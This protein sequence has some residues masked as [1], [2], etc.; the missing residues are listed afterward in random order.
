MNIRRAGLACVI[1]WAVS[2]GA[3]AVALDAVGERTREALALQREGRA[4]APTRPMPEP[5]AKRSYERYLE[6]FSHPIPE[7]FDRNDGFDVRDGR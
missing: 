6:S 5:A 2:F 4:A 1:G 7:Q 3:G